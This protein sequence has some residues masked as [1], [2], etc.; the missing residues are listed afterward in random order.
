MSDPH[1]LQRFV[2]A[3][4][5]VFEQVV[6]ELRAGRKKGHW[7]W[8]IFPQLKGL[9]FSH[10]SQKYGIASRDEAAAYARHPILGLRLQEC[11]QFVNEAE[12][13]SLDQILGYPDDLKF[14]SSMTLFAFAAP[15]NPV[16]KGALDK[17]FGGKLDENTVKQL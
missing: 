16:F 1:D 4:N 2:E 12:G 6:L 3:Q 14:H 5:R 17:Y 8:F 9:G 10:M 11:T 15:E 7:M 13:R